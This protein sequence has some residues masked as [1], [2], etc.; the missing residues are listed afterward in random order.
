MLNNS[1]RTALLLAIVLGLACF[2]G[3]RFHRSSGAAE[4]AAVV[5]SLPPLGFWEDSLD[6]VEGEV[7][8][9]ETFSGLMVRLGM[10][11]ADAYVLASR[12][13]TVFD[14]RK[15]RAGN[16][17]HAYYR[18]DSTMHRLEYVVYEN[19]R[20]HRTVF[21]CADSLAVW[22]V[23][24]PVE[25]QLKYADIT[26]RT[27]LWN[28]MV[29]AGAPAY[30]ISQL[31]EVYAWTVD[32][33]GLQKDDRFRVVYSQK[34]CEGEVI[35]VDTLY[36]AVFSPA[37]GKEI[38]AIMFDQGDGGN[39]YWNDRGES[40]RKAFLKAPLKFTRI[41]SGFSYHRKH[42]VTGVVKPHTAVDY[43]AP[44]GTPVMS[45]GDGTV[46][47][48]GWGGGGGNTVKIRHNSDPI[49][50]ENRAALDSVCLAYRALA[51]SLTNL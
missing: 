15:M 30:L 41:S 40:L 10:D 49:R 8:N 51:D 28:D 46:L 26:I 21:R 37:S 34:V 3:C 44:T 19:D 11:D 5:D 4:E 13:D 29:A 6:V 2:T 36:Y 33:F 43:A 32:F 25:R 12:L 50:P 14:V 39:I 16:H 20:V 35:D 45:I 24:K 42:P 38:P 7:R 27:S 22:R 48:A 47:S 23:T 17:W 9:G 1:Y 31:A 18:V